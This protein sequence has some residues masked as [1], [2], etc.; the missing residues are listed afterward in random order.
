MWY[1]KYLR[2]SSWKA[3]VFGVFLVRIFPHL[4]WIR[5]DTKYQMQE[6]T[7][8]KNFEYGHFSRSFHECSDPPSH[9]IGL[10]KR[11]YFVFIWLPALVT[12]TLL[13]CLHLDITQ[14]LTYW[15]ECLHQRTLFFINNS[16][17]SNARLKLAKNQAKVKQHPEAELFIWKL[18]ASLI[19]VITKK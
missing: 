1:N 8:Q 12:G 4:T 19:H 18:F 7:D 13:R 3:S 14:V 15:V 10:L 11:L 16:F 6:N 9:F 17:I 5:R 2:F